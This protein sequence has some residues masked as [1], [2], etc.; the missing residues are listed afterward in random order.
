LALILLYGVEFIIQ[1]TSNIHE[2]KYCVH[3][4]D[5]IRR[6]STESI[7]DMELLPISPKLSNELNIS[8]EGGP[9]QESYNAITD[10]EHKGHIKE[11]I[12]E[13]YE[14]A[15]IIQSQANLLNDSQANL[16]QIDMEIIA[17]SMDEST[18]AMQYKLDVIVLQ[19]AYYIISISTIIPITIS[20]TIHQHSRRLL[21]GA[22]ARYISHP[23]S[24][25]TKEKKVE[26]KSKAERL[27]RGVQI[28][29]EKIDNECFDMA[30]IED[31][32]GHMDAMDRYISSFHE[33]VEKGFYRWKRARPLIIPAMGVQVP[34][35]L[36]VPVVIDCVVDGF[37]I[38][39]CVSFRQ[40]SETY[41]QRVLFLL[42]SSSALAQY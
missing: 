16:S 20:I 19:Y 18:H 14:F 7:D 12:L 31:I 42:S 10:P 15:K 39:A 5:D 17:E 35:S 41:K 40:S 37:L 30:I 8:W 28:L 32:H 24:W 13:L 9:V 25:I 11:H 26:M 3:A 27:E 33:T 4:A 21:Q 34:L 29:I 22:E 23:N 2:K 36:M 6:L 38:G 1:S